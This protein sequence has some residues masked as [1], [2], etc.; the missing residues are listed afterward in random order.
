MVAG[1]LTT[2][3]PE[4]ATNGEFVIHI[5]LYV[6]NVPTG[7]ELDQRILQACMDTPET[8]CLW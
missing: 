7:I 5:L 8:N 6:K 1:K 2:V 4:G 3:Q